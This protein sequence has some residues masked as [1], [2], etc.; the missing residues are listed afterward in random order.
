[1][2]YDYDYPNAKGEFLC[3]KCGFKEQLPANYCPGCG[4]ELEDYIKQGL[5]N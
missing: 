3:P 4:R 2:K 5:T 1:M